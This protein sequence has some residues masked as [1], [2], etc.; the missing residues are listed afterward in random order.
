MEAVTQT[1]QIK[2][3]Q[4]KSDDAVAN[5]LIKNMLIRSQEDA[6]V[7]KWQLDVKQTIAHILMNAGGYHVIPD[8]KTKEPQLYRRDK[9][10][11][12]STGLLR[13]AEIL[14]TYLNKDVIQSNLTINEIK[15][16][17]LLFRRK[18]IIEFFTRSEEYEIDQAMFPMTI[19][20]IDDAVFT[21]LKRAY[22][23]GT[24]KHLETYLRYE[25][26][27]KDNNDNKKKKSLFA[28]QD[29]SETE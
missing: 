9:P 28:F 18:I 22:D 20:M 2:S 4:I 13:L 6:N 8:P 3:Q 24:R 27:I 14:N 1:Q 15:N 21:Q 5:A 19:N 26:R 25:E 17:Q 11:L 23:D 29:N 10:S 12:N 7:I 16:M